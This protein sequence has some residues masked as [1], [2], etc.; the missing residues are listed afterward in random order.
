MQCNWIRY[1]G[2]YCF[3]TDCG[4]LQGINVRP[5]QK[6]CFCGKRVNRLIQN[7]AGVFSPVTSVVVYKGNTYYHTD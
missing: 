1:F 7:S 2:E 6:T 3:K 4:H 5:K